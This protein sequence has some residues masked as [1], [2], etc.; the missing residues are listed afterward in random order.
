MLSDE[1]AFGLFLHLSGYLEVW[2]CLHYRKQARYLLRLSLGGT[3][4]GE[5]ENVYSIPLAAF[6]P[7]LPFFVLKQ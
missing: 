1:N 4:N 2:L 5:G 6:L 3:D 7:T